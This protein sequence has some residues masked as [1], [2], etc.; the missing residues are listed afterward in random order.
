MEPHTKK[1]KNNEKDS[2]RNR[3]VQ[4][5]KNNWLYCTRINKYDKRYKTALM[6]SDTVSIYLLLF[7][8]TRDTSLGK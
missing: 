3:D 1:K 5:T 2:T 7:N 4:K 6:I 8:L